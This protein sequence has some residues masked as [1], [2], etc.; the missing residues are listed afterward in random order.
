MQTLLRRLENYRLQE[1]KL[2]WEGTFAEYLDMAVK[3]PAA[4]QL[5]HESGRQTPMSPSFGTT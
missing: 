2:Q 5:S 1:T 4:A 3:N